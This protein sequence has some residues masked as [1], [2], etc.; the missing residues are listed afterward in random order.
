MTIKEVRTQNPSENA[1]SYCDHRF[2]GFCCGVRADAPGIDH[3]FDSLEADLRVSF[4][5]FDFDNLNS[6]NFLLRSMASRFGQ[7]A[8]P[9]APPADLFNIWRDDYMLSPQEAAAEAAERA[10]NTL[11]D[12][13]LPPF[14]NV[15]NTERD[16]GRFYCL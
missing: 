6:N 7:F 3:S 13:V 8:D 2:F 10:K 9:A 14:S 1:S 15:G 11:F 4:C 12:G 16:L 5:R